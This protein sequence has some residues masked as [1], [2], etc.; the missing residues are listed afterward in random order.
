MKKTIIVGN[1]CCTR[2]NCFVLTKQAENKAKTDIVAEK[3]C[4]GVCKITKSTKVTL[5]LL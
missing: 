5:D 3:K 4:S 1:Y 2:N